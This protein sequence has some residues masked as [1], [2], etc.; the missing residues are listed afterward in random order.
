[1]CERGLKPQDSGLFAALKRR[2]STVL[3]RFRAGRRVL[4]HTLKPRT[5]FWLIVA[6][7]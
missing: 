4:T 3:Q 1:M 5:N 7:T 2:A 6:D